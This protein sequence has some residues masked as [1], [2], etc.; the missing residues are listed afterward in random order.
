MRS[1]EILVGIFIAAGFGAL[2]MLATQVSNLNRFTTG[3]GYRVTAYFDNA[4]GLNVRSPVTVA[5]VRIG[6]VTAIR[7]NPQRYKAEVVMNIAP[8]HD[9][10]SVDT[11]ASI[12][13]AGL[14]GEQYVALEPGAETKSLADGDTIEF[15]QSALVLEE[16]IGR[17][18]VQLTTN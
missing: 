17:I 10:L 15:T 5:G 6:E 7:Y 12:Y 4:G 11:S 1:I 13:T 8:K 16:F 2:F 14:L 9:Y 18:L 3:E